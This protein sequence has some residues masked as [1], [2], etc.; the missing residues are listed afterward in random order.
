MWGKYTWQ[1]AETV[2]KTLTLIII[3]MRTL[4]WSKWHVLLYAIGNDQVFK[5]KKKKKTCCSASLL[6]IIGINYTQSTLTFII[7]TAWPTY[8]WIYLELTVN[9]IW[10]WCALYCSTDIVV[11]PQCMTSPKPEILLAGSKQNKNHALLW[12]TAY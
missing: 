12:Y 6:Y 9:N 7:E 3:T 5:K 4:I 1:L 10:T 11:R 2:L 8:G